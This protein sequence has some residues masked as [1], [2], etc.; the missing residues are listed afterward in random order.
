MHC[1]WCVW[2]TDCPDFWSLYSVD[3]CGPLRWRH[4]VPICPHDNGTSQGLLAMFD[5][6]KITR[7]LR[8]GDH[9]AWELHRWWYDHFH[10][11]AIQQR[12]GREVLMVT[13]GGVP[14]DLKRAPESQNSWKWLKSE[15]LWWCFFSFVIKGD[16]F[17]SRYCHL[18]WGNKRQGKG[19][20]WDP[21]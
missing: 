11:I 10:D 9:E 2:V 14:Q 8:K 16:N 4:T 15:V 19:P 1:G 17:L 12:A 13:K 6:P 5:M 3:V 18:V 21:S 7:S 20:L